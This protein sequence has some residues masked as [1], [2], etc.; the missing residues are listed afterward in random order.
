MAADAEENRREKEKE[1]LLRTKSDSDNWRTEIYRTPYHRAR[2]LLHA[3]SPASSTG[4]TPSEGSPVK[5][6]DSMRENWI[7]EKELREQHRPLL[8]AGEQHR[9]LVPAGEQQ[10]LLPAEFIRSGTPASSPSPPP[11]PASTAPVTP[12][13]RTVTPLPLPP[14]S[15]AQAAAPPKT[16]RPVKTAPTARPDRQ[17][18]AVRLFGHVMVSLRLLVSLILCVRGLQS[19]CAEEKIIPRESVIRSKLDDTD[20]WEVKKDQAPPGVRSW[21]SLHMEFEVLLFFHCTA[22]ANLSAQAW[23]ELVQSLKVCVCVGAAPQ[24]VLWPAPPAPRFDCADYFRP[25]E[26]LN[27]SQM[28]ELVEFLTHD[29]PQGQEVC[30]QVDR[31]RYG[32]ANYLKTS[33]PP[34]VREMARGYVVELVQL[35][36]NKNFLQFRKGKVSFRFLSSFLPIPLPSN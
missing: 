19:V 33:G 17:T 3:S 12:P 4:S 22:V 13:I 6:D 8:P 34:F 10:R 25:Q 16:T 30:G 24:R 18:V 29:R 11:R 7:R 2:R 9:P 20:Q 26:R 14:V 31:G 5:G 27:A 21:R 23:L 32:F 1:R 35:L 15:Y 36:L 28:T